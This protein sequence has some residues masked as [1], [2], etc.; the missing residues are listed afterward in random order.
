[1]QEDANGEWVK[2][3]EVENYIK[4]LE[5]KIPEKRMD[6]MEKQIELLICQISTVVNHIPNRKNTQYEN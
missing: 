1:M 4:E 6:K 5:N 3:G 2:W